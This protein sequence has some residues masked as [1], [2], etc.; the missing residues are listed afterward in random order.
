MAHTVSPE[1][2][3]LWLGVLGGPL[4]W[5]GHFMIVYALNGLACSFGWLDWT[6]LGIPGVLLLTGAAT[7]LAVLL[8]GITTVKAWRTLQAIR[9]S[10]QRE[11]GTVEQRT[12][13]LGLLGV[14]LGTLFAVL[15]VV[16]AIPMFL[17]DYC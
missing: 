15:M 13:F 16:E 17:L 3:Q 2:R 11:A 1:Q 9:G 10:G 4:I 6:V 5:G 7:A 12:A 14:L 8:V